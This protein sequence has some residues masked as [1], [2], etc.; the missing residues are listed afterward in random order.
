MSKLLVAIDFSS[1]SRK[2]LV[3]AA[4]LARRN[5]DELYIVYVRKESNLRYAIQHDMDLAKLTDRDLKR[6]VEEHIRARFDSF[7]RKAIGEKLHYSRLINRGD[8]AVEIS[9]I[10]KKIKANFVVLGTRGT[11]AMANILIGSTAQKVIQTSPCPVITINA[12]S[13]STHG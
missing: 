1:V 12:R 13:R 6:K 9:R 2:A 10:A 7:V 3:T 4:D 5:R 8:P 11:S